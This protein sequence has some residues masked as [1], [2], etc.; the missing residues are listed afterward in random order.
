MS[1]HFLLY[2]FIL[3]LF[4]CNEIYTP[5]PKG[6]FKIDY[7]EKKYVVFNEPGYPYSFEYPVYGNVLKDSTFFDSIAENPYWVNVDFPEFGARF[8]LSYKSMNKKEQVNLLIQ[9]AFKM[10]GKHSI[11]A[12]YIDEIP[13]EEGPGKYGFIFDVGGNAATGKQFYITD[14]THHFIRGA[15][16]FEATPNFDSISPSEQFLYKDMQHMI[17]TL[18]WKN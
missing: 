16:Y 15:L 18:Q 9:D 12:S 8:H 11:K 3:A 1:R 6:Y 7:P 13:L 5:K 4:S 10:T 14:S 17:K 2:I